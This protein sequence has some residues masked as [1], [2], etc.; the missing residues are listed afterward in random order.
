ML[1]EHVAV[2]FSEERLDRGEASSRDFRDGKKH[3][4]GKVG[5]QDESQ[6]EKEDAFGRI[7]IEDGVVVTA[8]GEEH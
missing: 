7:E 2:S 3:G 4:Y 8:S 1:L 5:M 6:E